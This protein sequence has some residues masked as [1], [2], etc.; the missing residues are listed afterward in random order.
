MKGFEIYFELEII[1]QTNGIKCGRLET[2]D[3]KIKSTFMFGSFL[4]QMDSDIIY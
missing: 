1:G 2:V 4:E 3:L